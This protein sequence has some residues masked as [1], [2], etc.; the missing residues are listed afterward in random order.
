[1]MWNNAGIGESG[2]FEDVPYDAAM[3]VLTSTTRRY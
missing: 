1:M 3:R 2:W